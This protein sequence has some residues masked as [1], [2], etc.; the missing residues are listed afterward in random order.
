MPQPTNR[1]IADLLERIASLLESQGDVHR[2][3]AY[4][5]A[6]SAV[7][8][9]P[10]PIVEVYRLHG[11]AGLVALPFI[12][13]S[14]ATAIAEIVE[15]GQSSLLWRLEGHV[16]PEDRFATVAGI[17]DALAH[18]I[19]A[20]L[21]IETLEDLE[22]AAHDGRLERVHG[23]G[24]NRVRAVREVLASRLARERSW[25]N[26]T[27]ETNMAPPDA[28]T[29]LAVDGDYRDRARR[30]ELRK[31]APRRFNPTGEAWLP[32]LHTRRDGWSFTALFSNSALAHSLR[33]TH[34]WVLVFFE[35]DGHTGQSTVVTERRGAQ[36][37]LRVIRGRESESF[38]V[39]GASHD[40]FELSPCPHCG[41]IR[42]PIA[43]SEPELGRALEVAC[44]FCHGS[45]VPS[46]NRHPG[47]SPVARFGRA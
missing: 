2:V 33:R 3:V 11:T 36:A 44:P 32:I 23:F 13:K 29:I 16:S 42:D 17:G 25:L 10:H 18:R 39:H 28:A 15:T 34:D 19:V 20:T 6:A 14:I 38:R 26:R 46:S 27:V 47:Q 35:R 41:R 24:P 4:R 37:G 9:F 30:D 22:L 21:G 31:I 5:H 8:G 45:D 1:D 7:R 12:G 43:L 40:R